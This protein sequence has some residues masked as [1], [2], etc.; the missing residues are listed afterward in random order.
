MIP[1][2]QGAYDVEAYLEWEMTVDQKFSA[3]LSPRKYRVRQATSEIKDF[4]MLSGLK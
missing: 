3:H 4:A 2:F 1:S